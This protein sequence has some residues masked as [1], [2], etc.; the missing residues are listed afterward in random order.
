GRVEGEETGCRLLVRAVAL[1]AVQRAGVAPDRKRPRRI[2]VVDDLHVDT[3]ATDAQRVLERLQD[4]AALRLPG[5]E[6][7][8]HHVEHCRRPRGGAAR[9]AALAARAGGCPLRDGRP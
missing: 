3:A 6:A 1:R 2:A 4:A 5:A 8:L 9:L 7:V